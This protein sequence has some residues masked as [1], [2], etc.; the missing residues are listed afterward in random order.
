VFGRHWRF[1]WKLTGTFD[2][3]AAMSGRRIEGGSAGGTASVVQSVHEREVW[4]D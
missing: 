1:R 2:E 3:L 4:W